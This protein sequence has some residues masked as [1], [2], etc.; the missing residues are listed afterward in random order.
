MYLSLE[1]SLVDIRKEF[2]LKIEPIIEGRR[3]KVLVAKIGLDGHDRGA[4]VVARALRDAGFDVVYLGVHQTPENVIRT[5]IEEDVDVIGI[6]ILSG[7]HI[8]FAQDITRLMKEKGV[9]IPII[10]GG[11]IPPTDVPI[12]KKIGIAEVHGPGTP[13]KKVIEDVYKL[14]VEKRRKER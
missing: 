14:A 11:I 9:N 1:V 6:S 10:F 8:E 5:A 7:S 4:K 3:I 2:G 13:L 12:L